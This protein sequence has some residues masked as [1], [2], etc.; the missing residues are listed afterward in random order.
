MII[1][2]FLNVVVLILGAVFSWLPQITTLPN[3]VDYDIDTA[4][5][6]GV[7]QLKS[8][9]QAMWPIGVMFQGFLAI[10]FYFTIKIILRFFLGHRSPTD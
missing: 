5:V 4:L 10:L 6:T 3:I 2:L 7:G 1:N 9:L 8:F